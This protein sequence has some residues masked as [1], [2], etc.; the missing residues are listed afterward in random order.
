MTFPKFQTDGMAAN[1]EGTSFAA[2]ERDRNQR[3]TFAAIGFVAILAVWS[4]YRLWFAQQGPAHDLIAAADALEYRTIEARLSGGFRFKPLRPVGRREAPPSQSSALLHA[5][6]AIGKLS[7]QHRSVEN[8]HTVG[9]SQLLLGKYDDAVGTLNEALMADASADDVVQALDKTTQ[10]PL[11][12]DVSGAYQARG[13][14]RN[15]SQDFV[16]A[17]EAAE[18]AWQFAK[19]PEVAWNRALA[20]ESL[21]LREDA[22]RAWN[23]YL[24]L[25]GDSLWARQARL[26]LDALRTTSDAERWKQSIDPLRKAAL[27]GDDARIAAIVS[28]YPEQART[29]GEEDM[30]IE[31]AVAISARNTDAADR[32]LR[33]AKAIGNALLAQT[34]EATLSDSVDAIR[35]T[36]AA[37]APAHM[38]YRD[39]QTLQKQQQM[40]ESY[41]AWR[42]TETL[43]DAN[44][45]PL[46]LRA[47]VFAESAN[48]FLGNGPAAAQRLSAI[49]DNRTLDRRY[50]SAVAQAR[51][52]RALI[53]CASGRQTE[54]VPDY[55]RALALFERIRETENVAAIHNRLATNLSYLGQ[56]DQAWRH[57]AEALRILDSYRKS[58]RLQA[59]LV[60]MARAAEDDGYL[61]ASLRFHDQLVRLLRNG[62]PVLATDALRAR[63]IARWKAGLREGALTDLQSALAMSAGVRDVSMRERLVANL[64]SAESIIFRTSQPDRAVRAATEAINFYERVTNRL[65]LVDMHIDRAL[66]HEAARDF[67]AATLDLHAATDVLEQQRRSLRTPPERQAFLERRRSLFEKGVSLF[68]DHADFDRAITFGEMARGRSILDAATPDEGNA[69]GSLTAA[70][71]S[72]RVPDQTAI[73]WYAV[74]PDRLVTN[75]IRRGRNEGFVQKVSARKLRAL[76]A[77]A[78][79]ENE[80]DATAAREASAELY[81]IL[82]RPVTARLEPNLVIVP[83][84]LLHATAIS[85]LFDQ[86]HGRYLIEDHELVLAPSAS[87][88]I[89]HEKQPP[90]TS[91]T[92]IFGNPAFESRL[93]PQLSLLPGAESEAREIAKLYPRSRIVTSGKAT[94]Q[95]FINA[96]GRGASIHYAGHAVFDSLDGAALLLASSGRDDGR[97]TASDIAT[98]P[99][100]KVPLVVL[101]ACGTW[102]QIDNGSGP[103]GFADVF[104]R[105]GV[106]TVVASLAPVDDG[107]SS[108][109]LVAFHEALRSGDGPATALRKA[110]CRLIHSNNS[111]LRAPRAWSRFVVIM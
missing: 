42:T 15:R 27:A 50:P 2:R 77:R 24:A 84:A 108:R 16:V 74:L 26:R 85:G 33:V 14:Y 20:I 94:R 69:R 106:H 73:L 1:G 18:R 56:S 78:F 40:I 93:F 99:M 5:A 72:A 61:Y 45:S 62:D 91:E 19:T 87:I 81:D 37:L 23:D 36:G 88:F 89:E 96:A 109:L 67:N 79:G 65:R 11:L 103:L 51:W 41:K 34:G 7:R 46:A 59:L 80:N 43:L 95:E 71:I 82:I 30:L 90:E 6:A 102:K 53:L 66:D 17:L 104:L 63:S 28:R 100:G 111:Q 105:S 97:I 8:L 32:S 101:S 12:L 10:A 9:V 83:D 64:R 68:V 75:V 35:R 58:T 76:M 44:R 60:D 38:A 49:A 57:R 13:R 86:Q 31:W 110:Q 47:T 107:A 4:S 70:E 54:G 55:Q 48:Y 3:L 25:D 92:A 22:I 52:L 39:A 21:H 98:I 29:F